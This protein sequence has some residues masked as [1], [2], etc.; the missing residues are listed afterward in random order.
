MVLRRSDLGID[1]NQLSMEA[2][3]YT[4]HMYLLFAISS[5]FTEI[6]H[7]KLNF[8]DSRSEVELRKG[9][10]PFVHFIYDTR[11]KSPDI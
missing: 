5:L 4:V 8:E 6:R 7:R 10:H 3:V 11:T 9:R 1:S 2:C